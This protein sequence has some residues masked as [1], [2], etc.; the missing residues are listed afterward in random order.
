MPATVDG[1]PRPIAKVHRVVRQV[2]VATLVRIG[3]VAGTAIAAVLAVHAFG[4][5]YVFFDLKIYHGAV[6]WWASGGDLYQFVSPGTT[7][8]FTYPPFA[9]LV[10]L[11]MTA[12]TSEVAGWVNLTAGLVVLAFLLAAV[13]N[14]I[15]DRHG[16]PRWFVTGLAVP[17]A[18][19]TEPVRETL[20]YGQVNLLLAGLVIA[21]LVFLRR[22][23]RTAMEAATRPGPPVEE[24]APGLRAWLDT[25]WMTGAFA[26]VGVGLATAIKLTPALFIVYF[27]VTRQWRVAATAVMTALAVTAGTFVVAGRESAE[28]FGG[29]GLDTSRVG[30]VDAT[31]NQ[32]LAGVLARLYDSPVTPGL[33]WLAFALLL[34][35]VG[36]S[37]AANAH[38]EGDELTAFTLVG[39]TANAICPISWTHH[40]VF[41][42]PALV[43]LFD[44]ALRRRRS[45]RGLNVG[46]LQM[47]AG[48][49]HGLVALGLYVLL[50]TSP[51]W[52]YE[53]KLQKGV[54]HYADGFHGALAENSIALAVIVLVVLLP[55]R[56]GAEPAFYAEP[57]RVRRQVAAVVPA[58]R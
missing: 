36:L 11:P 17:L 55:W 12:F 31:A 16:W 9:A 4:R 58:A 32:S 35:A 6:V 54:S 57:R 18:A 38:S 23:A 20:G 40:L 29:V 13:L 49:R 15:A 2:G 30:A 48:A 51:I 5:E 50:V 39:L 44:T 53:H 46:R 14:P 26:G 33:M 37:R 41:L 24:T 28:Y 21:D 34:L 8:G 47:F 42:V 22:R 43:V 3:I 52:A 27:L 45:R 10:M 7:L 1:R 25:A 56:P 19:A